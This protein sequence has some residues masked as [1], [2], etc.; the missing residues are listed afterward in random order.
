MENNNPLKPRNHKLVLQGGL[1]LLSLLLPLIL[2][3]ALQ[4]GQNLLSGVVFAG[5]A[6]TMLAILLI[7]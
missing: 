2:H 1:F 3:A 7:A 5:L 6:L 4:S